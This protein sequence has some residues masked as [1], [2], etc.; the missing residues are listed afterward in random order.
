MVTRKPIRARSSAH[1]ATGHLGDGTRIPLLGRVARRPSPHLI[2]PHPLIPISEPELVCPSVLSDL[3]KAARSR[4]RPPI[5]QQD[6]EVENADGAVAIQVRWAAVCWALFH[7]YIPAT[8]D[9]R[10]VELRFYNTVE[11]VRADRAVSDLRK[12]AVNAR[13]AV[14]GLIESNDARVKRSATRG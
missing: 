2:Q 12:K 14:C 6:K 5:P 8:V 4:T 9:K 1:H 13:P 11:P 10:T 7:D 3:K